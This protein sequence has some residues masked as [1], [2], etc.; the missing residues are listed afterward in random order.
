MSQITLSIFI[1]IS[2]LQNIKHSNNLTNFRKNENI[3]LFDTLNRFFPSNNFSQIYK[4]RESNP[5]A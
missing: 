2:Y 4:N 1:I 3:R 5:L